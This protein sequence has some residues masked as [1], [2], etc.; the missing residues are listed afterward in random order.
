MKEANKGLRQWKG[1]R[2]GTYRQWERRHAGKPL[3]EA[4]L[5]SDLHD[6]KSK[7]IFHIKETAHVMTLTQE[8]T[9]CFRDWKKTMWLD[10]RTE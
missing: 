3:E 2:M 9:E 5:N 4:P 8:S 7:K 6:Q 1:T 10:Y